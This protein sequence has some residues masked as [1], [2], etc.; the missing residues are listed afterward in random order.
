MIGRCTVKPPRFKCG[1]DGK[2]PT[3]VFVPGSQ[4]FDEAWYVMRHMNLRIVPNAIERV[5]SMIK[6]SHNAIKIKKDRSKK[7][8]ARADANRELES[9][10]EAEAEGGVGMAIDDDGSGADDEAAVDLSPS[11][12]A[13]MM[14][15]AA[16]SARNAAAVAARVAR[17]IRA[18]ADRP[19]NN[20]ANNDGIF[21]NI[22]VFYDGIFAESKSAFK[23]LQY[24]AL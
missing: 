19:A 23:V 14:D 9:N 3:S 21:I 1:R 22:D 5:K 15:K 11:D 10:E 8:K 24:K 17:R 12:M 16:A 18:A 13:A 4:S 20:A 7:R 2:G 6:S